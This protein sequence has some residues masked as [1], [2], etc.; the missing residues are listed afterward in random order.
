MEAHLHLIQTHGRKYS[1]N[2]WVNYDKWVDSVRD[3]NKVDHL[4]LIQTHGRKYKKNYWVGYDKWLDSVRDYKQGQYKIDYWAKKYHC[5]CYNEV[6]TQLK[7][8][9]VG[10]N[11][12][13]VRWYRRHILRDREYVEV[14]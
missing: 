13:Q 9:P 7:Y 3:K 12:F 1:K 14:R 2:Y 4:H 6:M 8:G 11:Y 10:L 5:V